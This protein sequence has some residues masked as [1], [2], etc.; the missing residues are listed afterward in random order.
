MAEQSKTT[1]NTPQNFPGAVDIIECSISSSNGFQFSVLSQTIGIEVYEDIFAPFM[2]GRIILKDAL[3]LPNLFPL[4][5]EE[6]LTLSFKTPQLE[7]TESHANTYYIVKM[8]DRAKTAEKEQIYVLH[9]ISMEAIANVNKKISRTYSGKV[10]DIA[11]RLITES[12]SLESP[13]RYNI[14]ETTTST[15]YTSN[16][17]TPAQNLKYLTDQAQNARMEPS[18]VF[19]ENRNGFHF[20]SLSTLY[21]DGQVVQTFKWDNYTADISS[22][23]GSER[24]LDQDYQRILEYT[25]PENFNY[26]DRL[27]SGVYGSQMI[28]YDLTTKMYTHTGYTPSFAKDRHLNKFPMTTR[29]LLTSTSAV[30]IREHRYH[31][32]FSNYGDVTNTTYLQRRLQMLAAAETSTLEIVVA[33]KTNYAVGQK[34]YVQLPMSSE[35]H[36]NDNP[37]D[38]WDQLLSGNYIIAAMCHK[39]DRQKHECV[40]QVIKESFITDL[41]NVKHD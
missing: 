2:T 25:V 17:W 13:K 27:T 3:D 39:I 8:D 30:L 38:T 41:N 5:G 14:E 29:R 36:A 15:K 11:R 24:N 31:A 32:N 20:V 28:T 6:T 40:M 26:I 33:G 16:F 4:I 9:F 12:N 18:Y 21:G 10:S 23:G 1:P 35:L 7:D 34:V 22:T 37:D 19:F